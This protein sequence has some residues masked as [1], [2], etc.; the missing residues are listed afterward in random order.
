MIYIIEVF[1][2]RLT[3]IIIIIINILFIFDYEEIHLQFFHSIFNIIVQ[4]HF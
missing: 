3:I 4:F 2:F 1:N